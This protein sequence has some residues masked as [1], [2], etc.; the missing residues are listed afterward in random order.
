LFL[1]DDFYTLWMWSCWSCCEIFC[2]L[3]EF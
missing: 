1:F 3:F 2:I